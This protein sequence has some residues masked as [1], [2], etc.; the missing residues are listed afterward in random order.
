MVVPP[1][2]AASSSEQV[3]SEPGTLVHRD[4]GVEGRVVAGRD[5]QAVVGE[6]GVAEPDVV[7]QAQPGGAG[8]AFPDQRRAV[9][10][11]VLGGEG[12]PPQLERPGMAAGSLA[13]A[14]PHSSTARL[15]HPASQASSQQ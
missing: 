4:P 9:G 1:E 12:V 8:R 15:T 3:I 14:T 2:Q 7:D 6:R 13:G 10:G 5:H 11:A